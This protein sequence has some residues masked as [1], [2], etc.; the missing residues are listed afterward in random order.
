LLGRGCLRGEFLRPGA[1]RA[2]KRDQYNNT[3]PHLRGF[4]TTPAADT[5]GFVLQST[6]QPLNS[7]QH[8]MAGYDSDIMGWRRHGDFD[9][10][11]IL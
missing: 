3:Y 7:V 9:D 8:T 5:V 1:A 4:R 2:P 10:Y 11:T 6:F